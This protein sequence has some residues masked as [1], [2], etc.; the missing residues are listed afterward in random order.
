MVAMTRAHLADPQLVEK[1][2]AGH[3]GRIRLCVGA[4]QGCQRRLQ[5]HGNVACTVNPAAGREWKWAPRN[6]VPAPPG[7]RVLVVGGGPAG[8]KA[9][10]TA[11][12]RGCEVILVER[13][14]DLGGQLR[15][16]GRLPHRGTWAELAA[17][18]ARD[19]DH[20]GVEVR[21]GVEADRRLVATTGADAV[22]LA[23]GADFDRSGYSHSHPLPGGVPGHE[24]P[25]VLDPIAAIAAPER[26]GERV[27]VFDDTGTQLALGLAQLATENGC[28]V[29][30]VS[31]HLYAGAAG[32]AQ[33]GDL[34]V[35]YPQLLA[36]GVRMRP[37]TTLREIG[38]GE[39]V[40]RSVWGGPEE[41]LPADTVV[42]SGLRHSRDGLYRELVAAGIAARRIGDCLAPREVD[43][44]MFEAVQAGCAVGGPGPS[45]S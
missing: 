40:V 33:T 2:Q 35:A 43:D 32:L 31:R 18:M 21:R 14:A 27:V 9:A 23:T 3:L 6:F 39:V 38:P 26:L 13:D 30:L 28:Q 42:L 45:V 5:L 25:H 8:M 15:F 37:Q 10:E 44:A 19:L 16:A 11:A 1:A 34:Q 36:A 4:N 12:L 24:L 22:I 7:T 41:R 17:E 29:E 20:L